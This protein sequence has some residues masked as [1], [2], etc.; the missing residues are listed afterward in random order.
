MQGRQ[1]TSINAIKGYCRQ[2]TTGELID[3]I[4]ALA[5][6]AYRHKD[7]SMLGTAGMATAEDVAVTTAAGA[8]K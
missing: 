4:D 5:P 8:E 3:E 1:D 6:S 2:R 7:K